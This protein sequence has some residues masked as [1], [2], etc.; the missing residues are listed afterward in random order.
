MGTHCGGASGKRHSGPLSA[1]AVAESTGLGG[2][3]L[4]R[5]TWVDRDNCWTTSCG[6][7][8]LDWKFCPHCGREVKVID[9]E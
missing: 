6:V 3:K 4:C 5:W 2:P 1:E 7:V 8:E 9:D